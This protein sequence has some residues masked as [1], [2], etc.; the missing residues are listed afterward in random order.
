[1]LSISSR[2]SSKK[3]KQEDWTMHFIYVFGK[4][5]WSIQIR[6]EEEKEDAEMAKNFCHLTEVPCTSFYIPEFLYSVL[7][8]SYFPNEAVKKWICYIMIWD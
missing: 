2:R 6:I 4:F 7:H 5:K 3:K 1:M 8:R